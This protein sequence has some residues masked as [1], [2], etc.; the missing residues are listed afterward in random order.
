MKNTGLTRRID[1]LG[2]IVIPNEYRTQLHI[3]QGDLLEL[4]LYGESIVLK[5]HNAISKNDSFLITYL[6]VLKKVYDVEIAI[7]NLDDVLYKTAGLTNKTITDIRTAKNRI[8]IPINPKGDLLGYIILCNANVL[9]E[10]T[11]KLIKILIN[12]LFE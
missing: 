8:D 2:R 9:D 4:F 12:S 7:I 6:N 5:K 3:K 1:S 10:D 11:I